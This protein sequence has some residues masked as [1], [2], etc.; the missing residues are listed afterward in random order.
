MSKYELEIR[1]KSCGYREDTNYELVEQMRLHPRE[2]LSLPF[3]CGERMRLHT[4]RPTRYKYCNDARCRFGEGNT[5]YCSCE[6][7]FHGI[8]VGRTTQARYGYFPHN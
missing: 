6:G 5:C 2:P 4:Y 3:H 8:E 1:C 7:T